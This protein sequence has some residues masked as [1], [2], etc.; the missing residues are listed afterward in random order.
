MSDSPQAKSP[1]GA[2]INF[3]ELIS[4]LLDDETPLPPRY[5]YRLSDIEGSELE[6]FTQTWPQISRQRRQAL[7]ED[8]E[9]LAETNTTLSFDNICKVVL[10][11]PDPTLV[12]I[13][14]RALWEAEDISLIDTFAEILDSDQDD[15]TRAQAAAG[16]GNF[17]YLVEIDKIPSKKKD[18]IEDN[19][20]A[21]FDSQIAPIIRRRALESLGYS[22]N[23]RIPSL[24]EEAYEFGDEEWAASALLAMGRSADEQ[25]H[26]FVLDKLDHSNNQIRI[27]A[28]RAAGEL[29][30]P[31][32]VPQLLALLA[33][34]DEDIRMAAVWALSEIGAD[35]AQ[36]AFENLLEQ[37]EDQAEIDL[38]EEALQNLA[39][40]Q[41]L[42]DFNLFDFSPEDFEDMTPTTPEED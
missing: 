29:E 17:L 34:Y 2:E 15:E 7:L 26:P 10:S 35:E 22:G 12:K 21:A 28:V 37:T 24:I 3:D 42:A 25:W 33:D 9:E 23:K 13:A 19:L 1:E 8:L 30:I 38:I 41:E 32:A 31:Q 4:A 14:I 27:E 40:N 36:D 11:D 16:L 6:G 39:F 18:N 20:L 5:L